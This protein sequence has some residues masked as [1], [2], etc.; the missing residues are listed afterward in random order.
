MGHFLDKTHSQ[1]IENVVK[2]LIFILIEIALRFC[3]QDRQ[4]IDR[5]LGGGKV[6]L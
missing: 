6:A 2:K 3:L 5:L 4:D 1:F